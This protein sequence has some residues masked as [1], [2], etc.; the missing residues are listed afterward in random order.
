[1]QPSW[2]KHPEGGVWQKL[3]FY[4]VAAAVIIAAVQAIAAYTQR[5]MALDAVDRLVRTTGQSFESAQQG[6]TSAQR[7]M[8]ARARAAQAE[9][10]KHR[11]ITEGKKIQVALLEQQ[12]L[13]AEQ[14]A[15]AIAEAE[16]IRDQQEGRYFPAAAPSMVV[17]EWACKDRQIVR[18]TADGWMVA[19]DGSGKP[20]RCRIE[21]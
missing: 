17:G 9:A 20:G 3:V 18:R 15:Q 1:M 10:D 7:S 21:P 5:R 6:I 2:D 13:A 19:K 14:R 8:E 12:R 11:Q 16:R 4:V